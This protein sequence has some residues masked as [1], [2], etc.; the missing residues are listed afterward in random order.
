MRGE[1]QGE[2]ECMLAV[3]ADLTGAPLSQVRATALAYS[4]KR[5]WAEVCDIPGAN[6]SS[7]WWKT[8]FYLCDCFD[9]TKKLAHT[10]VQASTV[11]REEATQCAATALPIDILELPLKGKGVI[12]MVAAH[13][14]STGHIVPWEDGLAYDSNIPNNPGESLAVVKAFYRKTFGFVVQGISQL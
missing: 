3:I 8:V 14:P 7:L 1:R 13:D 11:R 2:D 12:V 10:L 4:Q 9:T 5:T 6:L